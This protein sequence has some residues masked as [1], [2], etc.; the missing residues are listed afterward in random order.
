MKIFKGFA[1]IGPLTDN[2]PKVVASVGELS[3]RS[4]TFARDLTE[5]TH[6]DFLGEMLIG[7]SHRTDDTPDRISDADAYKVL[8][9][10][11]WVYNQARLSK[12]TENQVDFQQQFIAA[13]GAEYDLIGSGSMVAFG[14]YW[15]PEFIEI[16]PFEQS[17]AFRWKVWF[18]NES[19]ENQYDEFLILV[20]PP[21][22]EL[23]RFFDDYNDVKE[24]IAN[25]EQSDMFDRLRIAVGDY[26]QTTQRND[27][28]TW[29]DRNDKTLKVDTN[30][31]TAH[32]GLAGDNLDAV[33]EAI[34]DYIMDH[35]THTRDEWA[36]IFPDIFTSTEFI[37]TPLW[38]D[39]A[40]PNQVRETGVY[41]GNIPF[42][43][44]M[45][46]CHRTCKGV[47]YTDLHIDAVISGIVTTHKSA[48]A[49]IVG[50]PENRDGIDMFYERYPDYIG[51]P[52]LHPDFMRMS[53]E[54]RNFVYMLSKM[55]LEA[56]EM[57]LNS[58]VP[59]GFNR[60]VRDGVV[61]IAKSYKKFLYLV[62]TKYSVEQ[63]EA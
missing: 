58:G 41:S 33:K 48:S 18:A 9:A 37:I 10:I 11:N 57:T 42:Q 52:P 31:V 16:A 62:V 28:F 8:K 51:V 12:F 35:T 13:M 32:Y 21:I 54:T 30:W 45:A 47:R 23:D 22:E 25:V 20:I 24:M 50:G 1:Q 19:F 38:N 26:P 43:K 55:L 39:Y 36:E 14:N 4:R 44:A 49:A 3:T 53:E 15:A 56:E 17:G 63:L 34:R 40:I 59:Q 27:V 46:L 60:V 29:Q 5:H 2:A 7:F 61:Y 6:G